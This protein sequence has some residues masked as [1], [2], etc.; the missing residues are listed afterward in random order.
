MDNPNYNPLLDLLERP[1]FLVQDGVI[2]QLNQSA[3]Q[4]MFTVGEE[5]QHYLGDC[6]ASYQDYTAGCL[7][8]SLELYPNTCGASVTR[9]G[10]QHLFCLDQPA[11]ADQALALTAQQLRAP[12]HSLYAIAD[13]LPEAETLRRGLSQIH[14]IV[15]NMSDFPRY[16]E[17]GDIRFEET[18]LCS[19]F[20][21]TMEKAASLIV[22][23]G[24][25]LNYTALPQ[26]IYGLADR[27]MLERA[28]YNLISNAAKFSP[29]GGT[30]DAKLTNRGNMLSFT[31]QD[32]GDGIQPEILSTIFTR[33]LRAP[34]IEDS[35][36]GVGLGMALIRTVATYHGGTVL[37]DQPENGGTRV[38]MTITAKSSGSGMLRSPVLLPKSDFSGGHDRGLL[39]LS[40]VLPVDSYKNI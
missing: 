11:Q 40:D 9:I 36:H 39:E 19:I 1:A 13:S 6:L 16:Q 17:Q 7:Y 34:G 22:S 14:R 38:T 37:I 18:D 15:T 23:A 35:R 30:I 31:I 33:Y 21:E 26:N 27:E 5:I 2:V 24:L 3:A 12:L 29:K 28:V 4:K 32:Q 25:Q 8:L 20:S 10:T